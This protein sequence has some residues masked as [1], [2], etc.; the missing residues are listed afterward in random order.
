MKVTLVIG[1]LRMGGAQRVAVTL[2]NA[3]AGMGWRVSIVVTY[4]GHGGSYFALHQGV[5]LL[6]LADLVPP[7][8]PR[9]LDRLSRLRALRRCLRDQQPDVV[10]SLLTDANLATLLALAGTRLSCIVSER[11]YPPRDKVGWLYAQLRRWTYPWADG[12]VMQTARG[13]HWLEQEIPK[14]RGCVIANP[15]VYPLPKGGE[16]VEI[17]DVLKPGARVVLAVGRLAQQKGFD[18][19][20]DAFASLEEAAAEWT[21]VILGEGPDRPLLERQVQRLQL[22]ARVLLPGAAGNLAQW[23]ARADLFVMSSRFEGFPNTLTEAMA[24]GCA[25]VSF[26]CDTGPSEI[27]QDGEDGVLVPEGGGAPAL[28]A[29]MRRLLGAPELRRRLGEQ[30]Q[31]VRERF[32]QDQVLRL[33]ETQMHAALQAR[34]P[35]LPRPHD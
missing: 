26:D 6:F 5:Q 15:V 25:C 8:A 24:H 1:S 22:Q 31:Q 27:I 18:I 4:A 11:A 3:W 17:A 7:S 34:R 2:A 28:A 23:Y 13:L 20:V 19:L 21:L 12:V 35:A 30:A 33:W 16:A 32:S 9:A 14:A 29:A 10:L